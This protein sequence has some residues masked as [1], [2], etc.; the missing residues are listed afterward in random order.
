MEKNVKVKIK[1]EK[2]GITYKSIMEMNRI[3]S[4]GKKIRVD[5]EDEKRRRVNKTNRKVK[6]LDKIVEDLKNSGI[7]SNKLEDIIIA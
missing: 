1:I 5:I 6:R 7:V 2:I 4:V 3:S